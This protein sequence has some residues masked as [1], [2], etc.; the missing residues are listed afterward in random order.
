MKMTNFHPAD[1]KRVIRKKTYTKPVL[2][3]IANP[4]CYSDKCINLYEIFGTK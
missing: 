2:K 4:E 1:R 3:T